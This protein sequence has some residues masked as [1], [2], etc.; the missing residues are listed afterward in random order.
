[1]KRFGIA[2]VALVVLGFKGESYEKV[3]LSD[4]VNSKTG[5]LLPLISPDGKK[6]FFIREEH[7]KNTNYPEKGTQDIWMSKLDDNG[8]WSEARHLNHP[9]NLISKNA[10]IGFSAD[11]NT[12]YLKGYFDNGEYKRSGFSFTTLTKNGWSEPQGIRVKNYDDMLD[13][14]TTVTN[15]MHIDNTILLMSFRRKKKQNHDI[16][17]SFRTGKN[18]FSEPKP[19]GLNTDQYDEISP[20]LAAD[21]VTLYYSTN[22]AGGYGN[23]DIY[24]TR[25]LDDTWMNWSEPVNL[26]PEVNSSGWDAYYCIP[27]SGDVAYMISTNPKN[28]SSDICKIK[29]KEAVRPKPVVLV[30]GRV[31]DQK[32]GKPLSAEIVY[33]LVTGGEPIG[34]AISNE[35]TGEYQIV[36]PYGQNYRF[37]AIASGYYAV[38]ENMDLS[39][40]KEYKEIK[41]DLYLV[42]IEVG[43]VVRLNNIFFEFGKAELKQESFTEL[44]RVVT[45]LNDNPSMSIEIAGHTDNVGSDA[46]NL[47]LSQDRANAVVA[48]IVSKGIPASRIVAKGYGESVAIAD[49]NTEEGRAVNRRVEFKIV[50]R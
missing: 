47:K 48:Y 4:N 6:L 25:R 17:V 11:G 23:N 44:D 34:T 18:L 2:I 33:N 32:T 9:F 8:A 20:F 28:G 10:L 35:E 40:L 22:R 15:Y 50:N 39:N 16:Y 3:F 46:D 41:R 13:K 30:T 38:S 7:P 42:P 24:M 43:Q 12:R 31:L 26:G 1:M 5:E 45:L 29:L 19:I 27:A 49:N 36:L 14:G 21:G 37:N